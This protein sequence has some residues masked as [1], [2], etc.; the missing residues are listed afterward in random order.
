MRTCI[1]ILHIPLKKPVGKARRE[2]SL[3]NKRVGFFFCFSCTVGLGLI[4]YGSHNRQRGM[5]RLVVGTHPHAP[6]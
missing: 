4:F 1:G 6:T 3:S 5:E 2:F